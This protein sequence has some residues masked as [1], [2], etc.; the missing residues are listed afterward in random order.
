MSEPKPI[1]LGEPAKLGFR[2]CLGLALTGMS[3]RMFRSAVTMA[4]LALAVAFLAHMLAFGILERK[5]REAAWEKLENLRALGEAVT[6]LG[7]KDSRAAIVRALAR[8]K[9]ERLAEYAAWSGGDRGEIARGSRIARDFVAAQEQLEAL[10]IAA[11]AVILGDRS[12]EQVLGAIRDE[13]SFARLLRQHADFS[14]RPPLG[15]AALRKLLLEEQAVLQD[16]AARIEAG[17][18]R[19]VAAL[20]QAHPGRSSKELVQQPPPDFAQRLRELGFSAELELSSV[21]AFARRAAEIE[22]IEQLVLRPDARAR[23]ARDADIPLSDVDFET[24]AAHVGQSS[25]R[26]AWLSEV[27]RA[28]GAPGRLDGARVADLVQGF[29]H[30]RELARAAGDEPPEA[31]GFM[32]VSERSRW[33]VLL[34]FLVCMVGVANAM[35]MSVTERFT[36]IATMKCLGAL[37]GF[38]MTMFV[39]E[40]VIQGLVGGA[41]GLLLGLLL[42][43]LRGFAEFGSLLI[44]PG[45][46]FLEV[47]AAMGLSLLAGVGLAA[48]AAVG[49]AFVAARLA[50]ME[51]MRVD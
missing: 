20:L 40:A 14:L 51:A 48:L 22:L 7:T 12:A 24:V 30:E 21:S 13:A 46:A 36:E 25:S 45:P 47:L 17:H 43:V 4:I 42:A 29:L 26:A 1:V 2:R 9:P 39:L 28:A 33:L 18:A 41:A 11:R 50:P 27:L 3:Y 44:G 23:I 16:L 38:V 10:P 19:A 6:R 34:S 15:E 5:T 37:D 49:P 35:L 8:A 31:A 32:A